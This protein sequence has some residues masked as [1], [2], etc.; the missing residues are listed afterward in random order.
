MA[1]MLRL[2]MQGELTVFCQCITFPK[3]V[4]YYTVLDYKTAIA[5]IVIHKINRISSSKDTRSKLWWEPP[6]DKT[7]FRHCQFR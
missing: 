2:K 7:F 4:N 1:A 6:A 3:L 5:E